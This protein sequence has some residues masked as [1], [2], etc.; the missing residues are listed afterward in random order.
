M[1]RRLFFCAI[2]MICYLRIH[3]SSWPNNSISVTLPFFL[4]S[5]SAI[6][7]PHPW[8]EKDTFQCE[9]QSSVVAPSMFTYG[10]ESQ[11][12][13]PK[14][15]P[16]V[17]SALPN[18]IAV[19]S[20]PSG[21]FPA[22]RSSQINAPSLPSLFQIHNKA[23]LL[24]LGEEVGIWEPSVVYCC[25]FGHRFPDARTHL[26]F[27]VLQFTL[28]TNR[29]KCRFKNKKPKGVGVEKDIG[30]LLGNDTPVPLKEKKNT[31]G[32]IYKERKTLFGTSLGISEALN[33][34]FCAAAFA[35]CSLTFIME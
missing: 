23:V 19:C 24:C 15:R 30:I 25:R 32:R 7:P 12:W 17:L 20:S 22:A 10:A 11:W 33:S 6:P 9:L 3:M 28:K 35:N 27:S 2:N 5:L 31:H 18:D 4:L 29:Q 34:L 26:W 21:T 14:R 1:Y 16:P 13:P 8:S